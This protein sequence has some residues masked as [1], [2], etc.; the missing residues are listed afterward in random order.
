[1]A[2]AQQP[3][4]GT[5]STA[6]SDPSILTRGAFSCL[7]RGGREAGG[8]GEELKEQS[9]LSGKWTG[10]PLSMVSDIGGTTLEPRG[11]PRIHQD[12]ITPG[13]F[14]LSFLLVCWDC[15]GNPA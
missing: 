13:A 15:R 9:S 10:C 7:D 8:S 2:N 11:Q 12:S 1:M 3:P 5:V 4:R 6:V 14:I